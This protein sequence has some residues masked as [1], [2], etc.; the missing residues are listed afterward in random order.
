VGYLTVLTGNIVG[1]LT[2][3][4]EKSQMPRGLPRRGGGHGRFWNCPVHK[5]EAKEKNKLFGVNSVKNYCLGA[6][7][8]AN[9]TI[10]FYNSK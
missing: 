4:F 2:K 5:L 7:S 9:V 10:N 3:S 6:F 1:N 8:G